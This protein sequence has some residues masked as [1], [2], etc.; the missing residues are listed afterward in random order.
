[1]ILH[2]S[3]K[4]LYKLCAPDNSCMFAFL[5]I[6]SYIVNHIPHDTKYYSI[7]AIKVSISIVE[8]F[9]VP[10]RIIPLSIFEIVSSNE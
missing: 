7:A 10:K 8:N 6:L 5:T 4:K 3:N 9:F 1:M 2:A